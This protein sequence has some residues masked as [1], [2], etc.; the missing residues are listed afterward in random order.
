[1]NEIKQ[2]IEQLEVEALKLR[3]ENELG[4]VIKIPTSK[5]KK[6]IRVLVKVGR[7]HPPQNP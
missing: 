2:H 3:M 4:K 5:L 6:A 7:L 1:M